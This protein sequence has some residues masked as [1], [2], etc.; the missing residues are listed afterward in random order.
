M[1][2][3]SSIFD[4]TRFMNPAFF[5][6]SA[7]F[8]RPNLL[9]ASKFAS[10]FV[11]RRV[12]SCF[13]AFV[14]L[15]TSDFWRNF[16]RHLFASSKAHAPPSSFPV[17]RWC[18]HLDRRFLLVFCDRRFTYSSRDSEVSSFPWK[19]TRLSQILLYPTPVGVLLCVSPLQ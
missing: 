16:L 11:R 12:F 18:L 19:S 14:S 4:T 9:D 13:Y 15:R 7:R 10:S 5:W 1:Y 6:P 8:V 17:R 3:D 2:N